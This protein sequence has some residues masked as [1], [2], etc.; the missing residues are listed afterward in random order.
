MENWFLLTQKLGIV[1]S[2][3]IAFGG[4]KQFWKAKPNMI[5]NLIFTFEVL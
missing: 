1:A 5:E 4:Y 3:R 2:S